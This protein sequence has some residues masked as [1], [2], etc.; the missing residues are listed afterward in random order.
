MLNQLKHFKTYTG[1]DIKK[2][3]LESNKENIRFIKITVF[4]G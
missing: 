3:K 4:W 1:V 2:I